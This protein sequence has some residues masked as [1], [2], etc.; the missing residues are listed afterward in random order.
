MLI[1][2]RAA[3]DK[4]QEVCIN[5]EFNPLLARRVDVEVQDKIVRS[6]DNLLSEIHSKG[7]SVTTI[8]VEI[9]G[10]Y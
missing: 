6:V 8:L 2:V 10:R 4:G 5:T 1:L 3:T 7:Q 9:Q